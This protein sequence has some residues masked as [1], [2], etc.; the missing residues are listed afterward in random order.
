[1]SNLTDGLLSQ[2]GSGGIAQI[3]QALGTDES[4]A[5]GAIGS[6]LP[7]ILAGLANNTQK[8]Q[9]AE[10]LASALEDHSPSV[11]DQLG[12]V[13]KSA[14]GA[15]GNAILAHVLG[16]KR[17]GVEQQLA[18]QTGLDLGAI[19]KLLPMLAPLVLGYLSKQKSERGLDAGAL[20]SMLGEERRA[21]EAK[22]PGL[23]GLA[24]ILDADGDGSMMDD[25]I[26]LTKGGGAS[27]GGLGGLLSKVLGRR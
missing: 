5:Q 13:V 27:K 6:A 24:S 17:G 23:G 14:G 26:D 2:L 7:A 4:K 15:D 1:M 16:Q 10:A 25:L 8:P 22:S 19:S 21:S 20:G 18:G 3:A 12:N 11:F 9:G